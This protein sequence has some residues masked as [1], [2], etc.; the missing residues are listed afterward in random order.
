MRKIV[1]FCLIFVSSLAVL[2]NAQKITVTASVDSTAM[3]IGSQTKLSF[4]VSQQPKQV[5]TMPLFSDTIVGGVE[6]VEPLQVDTT[7]SPDGVLLLK[8]TYVVT[9]FEDSLFYI[10]PYPFVIDKD[11]VWSKS[12]SIKVVQPF[13]IDT[14]SNQI[15]DIKNVYTP[16]IYWKGIIKNILLVLFILLVAVAIFLI[17]R[18]FF[19]KKSVIVAEKVEPELPSYVIALSKLDKLKQEKSWQHNRSKE[20][21]TQLSD[22][23][24]EY[25]ENTFDVPCLEM[26]S[27]EIFSNMNHLRFES[28]NAFNSLQQILRLADLVKFAKWDATPDE[29]ELSLS[30]AYVFVNET[31]IEPSNELEESANE[32]ADAKL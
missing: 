23:V 9:A 21:H 18:R 15:T 26:T 29:H 32:S 22:I 4:E 24:R 20:Y 19:K 17:L 3:W 2:S 12:L 13:E 10:P 25:I 5:V 28:K 1:I 6:I 14:A 7:T 30:N 27:E 31:K 16:P 11:T 8:H